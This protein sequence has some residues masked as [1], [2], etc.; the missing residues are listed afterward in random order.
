M[1]WKVALRKPSRLG[2]ISNIVVALTERRGFLALYQRNNYTQCIRFQPNDKSQ[3]RINIRRVTF[4]VTNPS[5][6]GKLPR[7]RQEAT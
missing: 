5:T 7:F 6:P 4:V 1:L 2:S 3:M